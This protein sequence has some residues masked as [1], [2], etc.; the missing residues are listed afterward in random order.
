MPVA[1]A[2]A[3]PAQAHVRKTPAAAGA[4]DKI[5]GGQNKPKGPYSLWDCVCAGTLQPVQT[6]R[7]QS[8]G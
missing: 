5:W 2:P 7:L 4:E 6:E 1:E 3:V 8:G